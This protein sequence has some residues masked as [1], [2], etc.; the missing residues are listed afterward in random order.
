MVYD[1]L[2]VDIMLLEAGPRFFL[3]PLKTHFKQRHPHRR[4]PLHWKESKLSSRVDK[5]SVLPKAS[6]PHE[7][8]G[9]S[10]ACRGNDR[11]TPPWHRF[12][13]S[14]G[15]PQGSSHMCLAHLC[16]W[17]LWFG[18]LVIEHSVINVCSAS[19]LFLNTGQPPILWSAIF[20]GNEVRL[21]KYYVK[22]W[23][24]FLWPR[25][26]PGLGVL[27]RISYLLWLIRYCI[28]HS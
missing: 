28:A 10:H 15:V 3:D 1:H 21:N 27:W 14:A 16:T 26:F 22:G 23:M 11:N 13:A 8:T 18:L 7:G 24:W 20:R 2:W 4:I 5:G 25:V 17:F 12:C 9:H 19:E 6:S